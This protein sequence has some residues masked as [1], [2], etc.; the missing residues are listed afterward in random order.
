MTFTSCEPWPQTKLMLGALRE[1][2]AKR[3]EGEM[4]RLCLNPVDLRLKA[5]PGW[6]APYQLQPG[7][8]W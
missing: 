1:A 2:V 3:L 7:E 5:N 8:R 4:R 6:A